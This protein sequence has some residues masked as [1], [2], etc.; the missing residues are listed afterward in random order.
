MTTQSK[1]LTRRIRSIAGKA[2]AR[3]RQGINQGRRKARQG[4]DGVKRRAWRGL[5]R[6]R[7]R[8]RDVADRIGDAVKRAGMRLDTPDRRGRP[9]PM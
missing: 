9:E 2:K 8:A 1:D 3:L 5:A 4:L 7:H 6:V